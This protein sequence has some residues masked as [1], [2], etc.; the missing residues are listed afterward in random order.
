M[1]NSPVCLDASFILR[2]LQS[3]TPDAVAVQ[4]WREWHEAERMLVAPTLVYYEIANAVYRYAAHGELSPQEASELLD[5]ALGLALDLYGDADLHR[6]AVEIAH[7][8][9]LPATYDAHYLALAERL[10]AEFWTAD[11]RLFQAAQSALPWVNLLEETGS[12][13]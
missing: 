7:R 3:S 6:Q 2:L 13:E 11:R 9:P 8:L 1:P 5:M 12:E 10:G 4:V